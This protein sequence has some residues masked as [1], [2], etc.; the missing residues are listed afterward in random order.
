MEEIIPKRRLFNLANVL[1][2]SR[3][4]AAPILLALIL[5]LPSPRYSFISIHEGSFYEGT[6]LSSP[7]MAIAAFLLL[8]AALLTD[9]FDGRVAR[10]YKIVTNFGKIMDPIAD[11]TLFLTILFGFSVS[12][13]FREYFPIWFPL[14]V[15][16][17]EIGIQILR[18]YG[19]LKG[20]VLAAHWSGKA[21]MAIQSVLLLIWFAALAVFDTILYMT[22]FNE[23][24]KLA[25]MET[26]LQISL[27]WIG[28]VIVVVNVLSLLEYLRKAPKLME[29]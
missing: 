29:E 11:S 1:T 20:M 3:F 22:P 15:L 23:W 27:W 13:R 8:S 9:L 7:I 25:W 19:A 28:L 10:R 17:R 14:I 24:S 21:K 18:R 16:Y 12:E 5:A 4:A 2:L 26:T 6:L